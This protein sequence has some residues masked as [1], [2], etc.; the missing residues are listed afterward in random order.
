MQGTYSENLNSTL[1]KHFYSTDKTCAL[2]KF[3]NPLR[4]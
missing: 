4:T 3:N 1:I 2:E